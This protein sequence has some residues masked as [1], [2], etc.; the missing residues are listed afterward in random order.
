MA[1]KK[2]KPNTPGLRQRIVLVRS[3]ITTDKPEKSLT[4]NLHKHAGRDNFGRVSVRRRGGG[5]KRAY[6]V[7]DFRR[8]KY[9]VPGVVKF[10]D[11][12]LLSL[13]AMLFH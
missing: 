7:I 1:L 13:L 6:R 4:K 5:H 12:Q 10:L 3:E 9:G 11:L 8:D 2:Y